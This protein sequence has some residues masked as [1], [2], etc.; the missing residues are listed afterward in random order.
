MKRLKVELDRAE[1]RDGSEKEGV[2]REGGQIERKQSDKRD[3]MWI[4]EEGRERE[5]EKGLK[6]LEEEREKMRIKE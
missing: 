5:R 6:Q 1:E 3:N 4:K 2:R